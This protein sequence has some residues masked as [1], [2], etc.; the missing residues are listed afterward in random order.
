MD[1]DEY[2]IEENAMSG[3]LKISDKT[4]GGDTTDTESPKNS[5]SK[6]I[7]E[8]SLGQVDPK[9]VKITVP[10]SKIDKRSMSIMSKNSHETDI[11]VSSLFG[12]GIVIFTFFGSTCP[13]D[14]SDLFLL[15]EFSVESD[16]VVLPPPIFSVIFSFPLID[17]SYV[18]PLLISMTE[19]LLG[20]PL[21]SL[22][23][24]V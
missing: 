8:S 12:E 4:G 2:I 18:K 24:L 1:I 7:S 11:L 16:S 22:I 13:I 9:N 20:V 17:I 19:I 6:K 23:F 15:L 5:K 10:S 21:F 3:K 14:D